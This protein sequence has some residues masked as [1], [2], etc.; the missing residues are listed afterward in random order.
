MYRAAYI[1]FIYKNVPKGQFVALLILR[2]AQGKLQGTV[3][4]VKVAGPKIFFAVTIKKKL[5]HVGA[6]S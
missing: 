6:L 4:R 1:L 5:R 3:I 2:Q